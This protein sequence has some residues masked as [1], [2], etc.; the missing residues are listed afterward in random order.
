MCLDFK[1]LY[2]SV[3]KC[4][5]DHPRGSDSRTIDVF[6]ILSTA[7]THSLSFNSITQFLPYVP[8]TIYKINKPFEF[9]H[10]FFVKINIHYNT[11]SSLKEFAWNTISSKP[12][13][14]NI[15]IQTD[16]KHHSTINRVQKKKQFKRKKSIFT[17]RNQSWLCQQS[18]CS[19][20][21]KN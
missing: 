20:A 4:L 7:A 5:T 6:S 15:K 3:S 2:A 9:F 1:C 19:A 21:A 11:E 17:C 13:H 14:S 18:C 8:L 10:F 12:A 16:R